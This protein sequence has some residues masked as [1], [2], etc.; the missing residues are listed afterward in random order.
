GDLVRRRPDGTLDFLGRID[1]QVKIRG[2]RIELGEIEAALAA[3]PGVARAV[4]RAVEFGPGDSRLVGYV[5]AAPAQPAPAPAALRAALAARLPEIMV[6]AQ[7]VVLDRMPMTP[8]GKIDRKALPA[9]F[10]PAG[11]G[12]VAATEGATEEMIARIWREA[13]GLA[14]V[15]A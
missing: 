8:N 4:V 14:E 11:T 6:P 2:H 7:V 9:P 5:T 10:G 1:G 3:E 13:L 12:A 15:S